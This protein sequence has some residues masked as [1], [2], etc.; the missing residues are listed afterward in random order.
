MHEAAI[1]EGL[2]R[3]L[4]R[5]AARHG[6][7]AVRRVN[8]KVGRL[9]AVEPAQLAACFELFAEGTVA[10]GAKLAVQEL[11]VRA[12]CR[13]CGREFE[14]A[15]YR[16]ACP[17]CRGDDVVVTQGQELYMESFEAT[18]PGA[19]DKPASGPVTK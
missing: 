1:V 18:G 7:V 12:R 3:I 5:H 2:M 11:P 6:V 17:G 16:F 8:V 15:R 10:E 13:A 19:A 14:V 9:R 4:E